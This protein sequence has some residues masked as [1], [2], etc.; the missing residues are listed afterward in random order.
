[1]ANLYQD[2]KDRALETLFDSGVCRT[3]SKTYLPSS[4]FL[5]YS[6]SPFKVTI[7]RVAFHLSGSFSFKHNNNSMSYFYHHFTDG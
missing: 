7:L 5:S 3:R 1:M 6:P 4:L 2:F